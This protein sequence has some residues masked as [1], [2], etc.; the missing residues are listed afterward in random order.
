MTPYLGRIASAMVAI[1]GVAAAQTHAEALTTAAR[2]CRSWELESA[3]LPR[4]AIGSLSGVAALSGSDVWAVGDWES[5]NGSGQGHP[6]IEHWNGTRW[7]IV[8]GPSAGLYGLSSIAAVSAN[9]IWVVGQAAKYPYTTIEHWNGVHWSLA[10]SPR[11]RARNGNAALIGV[12][13][14]SATDVWAVGLGNGGDTLT[15]HWD[16]VRWVAIPSPSPAPPPGNRI[17]GNHHDNGLFDV[18][19]AAPSNVWAVGRNGSFPE[20][21][22]MEHW[23]GS[24]WRRV[25]L[26]AFM[27]RGGLSAVEAVSASDVWAVGGTSRPSSFAIDH[28]NGTTWSSTALAPGARHVNGGPSRIAMLGPRDG[29]AVGSTV[30]GP[31]GTRPIILHWDGTQ[32]RL[33]P[34][35]VTGTTQ[36]Q[37]GAVASTGRS[38]W[39]VG[40]NG[41]K[42]QQVPLIEH[43]TP[44]G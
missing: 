24:Q 28:W 7:N 32:W 27:S 12:T 38:V 21:P 9:D 1:L 40:M 34:S 3:P 16:G 6:L 44:C 4:H 18:S 39:A 42:G 17:P 31:R 29:W 26:P 33:T 14:L 35:P 20:R 19:G 10:R 15:E 36:A 41:P 11:I 13:A 8:D 25:T 37:L 22:L 23:N 2:A 5:Q 30:P 43:R